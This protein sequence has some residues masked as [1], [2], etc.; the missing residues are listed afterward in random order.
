MVSR[1]TSRRSLTFSS[2]ISVVVPSR[3]P[4]STRSWR[5]QLPSVCSTTPS[6][7]ATS[8]TVR[9]WSM[10]RA[11]ALRRNSFGYHL[12]AGPVSASHRSLLA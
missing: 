9:F 8:A 3:S 2:R 4:R 12:G 6:S 1:F 7:R 10:T 11:A 5:T